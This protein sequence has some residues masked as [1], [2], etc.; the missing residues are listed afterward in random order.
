MGENEYWEVIGKS[1][2]RTN[3]SITKQYELLREIFNEEQLIGLSYYG[4]EFYRKA[5]TSEFAQ[6]Y[7]QNTGIV[8]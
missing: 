7:L 8:H 3:N 6:K 5:Y 1:L 4:T 2:A